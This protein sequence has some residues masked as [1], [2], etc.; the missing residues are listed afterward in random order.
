[1]KFFKHLTWKSNF[2][3]INFKAFTNLRT[4]SFSFKNKINLFYKHVHPDILGSTCP[5]EF[6]K[7]N[8]SSVQDLNNYIE[9]LGKINSKY[10]T[11]TIDF[12]IKIEDN[13][14]EK[15]IITFSKISLNLDKIEPSSQESTKI[16]L[17]LK[18]LFNN[19]KPK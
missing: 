14:T 2:F 9:N 18:Y 6:R 4:N 17:Q 8:E 10:D 16:N 11:K 12:Y 5:P 13:L 15:P 1:M 3:K 7:V 19:K